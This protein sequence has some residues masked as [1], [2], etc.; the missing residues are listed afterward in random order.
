MAWGFRHLT[1]V[2]NGKVSFSNPT[3]QWLFDFADCVDP[4]H[5]SEGSI[6]SK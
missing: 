2:D 6:P 4:E 1:F 5:P 3:R